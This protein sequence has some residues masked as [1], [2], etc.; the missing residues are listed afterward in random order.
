MSTPSCMR[1]VFFMTLMVEIV[2]GNMRKRLNEGLTAINT[3]LGW[4]LCGEPERTKCSKFRGAQSMLITNLHVQNMKVSDMWDL[5]R[6]GITDE[7]Q[8]F[9]TAVED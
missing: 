1:E 4:I 9:S 5:E 7:V 8:T 3:K 6:I 2:S